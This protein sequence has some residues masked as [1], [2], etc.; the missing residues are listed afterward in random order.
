MNIN[1]RG[2]VDLRMQGV[3]IRWRC[4]I[5]EVSEKLK[6]FVRKELMKFQNNLKGM[7]C[8]NRKQIFRLGKFILN[9]VF[10]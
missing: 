8:I 7:I 6:K 10:I 1:K 3:E 5:Y 4:K 9:K 2:K